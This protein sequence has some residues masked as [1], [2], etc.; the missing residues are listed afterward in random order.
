M[1]PRKKPNVATKASSTR[2]PPLNNLTQKSSDS[3]H[4]T[5]TTTTKATTTLDL[6]QSILDIFRRAFPFENETQLKSTVQQVKGHL[7]SRDFARA[8]AKPQYLDAYAV[9]WSSS[10]ALAYLDIFLHEHLQPVWLGESDSASSVARE[11]VPRGACNILCIG[12]GAGAEVAACVAAA[13]TLSLS[14][15]EVH[16]LDLADWGTCVG[17]LSTAL[18]T[19]P[20]LSAHASLSARAANKPLIES[21]RLHL[22]FSQHDVLALPDNRL[23]TLLAGVNLCT[24]MFTL[25]ELFT[26]S[27]S[28]TTAFLL[29]LTDAMSLASWLLV[30]DSPGS[31]SEVKLGHGDN[32]K[33]KQY[34]MKWLLDHTLLQ[35]AGGGKPKWEKTFSDNSRW[36]RLNPLLKYPIELE[37]MRYQIHLYR[38]VETES[39]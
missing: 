27:T 2:K 13:S 39:S 24:I 11:L 5:T 6:Q 37:N 12:G 10:R 29:A 38:R 18:T 15:V 16:A 22:S 4:E 35:V 28:R 21:D 17:K 30:V 34:P 1:A 32:E 3:S 19:P 20:P 36:F 9:R 26:A 8:F 14:K 7:F 33:T 31:Y 23:R 25:N